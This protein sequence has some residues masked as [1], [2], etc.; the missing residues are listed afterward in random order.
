MQYFD[1]KVFEKYWQSHGHSV[2]TAQFRTLRA[3]AASAAARQVVNYYTKTP[4]SETE[5]D[6]E[7]FEL[8]PIAPPHSILNWQVFHPDHLD[9][10]FDENWLLNS[11]SSP[12]TLDAYSFL[13]CLVLP[14]FVGPQVTALAGTTP[15][16]DLIRPTMEAF[17]LL[18]YVCKYD[19]WISQEKVKDVY[20][21]QSLDMPSPAFEGTMK[22]LYSVVFTR[23]GH[24]WTKDATKIYNRLVQLV[25]E[26]RKRVTTTSTT[27]VESVG[28]RALLERRI[29]VRFRDNA[30]RRAEEHLL[31]EPNWAGFEFIP[32]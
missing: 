22:E 16:S 1:Q 6:D 9:D 13:V 26:D 21:N 23:Q 19:R 32:I 18:V 4:S 11:M 15:L 28:P 2:A 5:E 14:A 20:P 12:P 7:D 17:I 25:V 29:M 8:E 27:G 3:N 24:G 30:Q 10:K 31:S